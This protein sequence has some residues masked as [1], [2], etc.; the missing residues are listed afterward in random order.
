MPDIWKILIIDPMVNSLLFLYQ[1]LFNNFTLSIT[2][3]TILVRVLTYPL[4]AQSQKSSKKMTEL[5]QSDEW[6]KMQE[7][8]AKDR[9]KLSQEQMKLYQHAG[10]N[11][12]GG[13]LP[14]IIQFPIL[15]G[16]YQAITLAMA[17]SPV[18]LFSLSQHLYPFLPNVTNLIPLEN[19]FLWLNLGLPDPY[20][21]LPVVVVLS[22][23]IQSKVMTPPSADAQAAQMSQTMAIYMPL[24]IGWMS[25]QFPSGLSLYWVISNV[26][27]IVQYVITPGAKVDWKNVFSFRRAPPQPQPAK[28]RKKK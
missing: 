28:A 3:F 6:K 14:M 7:K 5:Q 2:V 11:P 27:G 17:A 10:V 23:W 22:T 25:L 8:Y 19:H 26:I 16:L 15:I 4:N 18:Q 1:L 9:E 12:F 21:V 13:C 20:Y 24:M